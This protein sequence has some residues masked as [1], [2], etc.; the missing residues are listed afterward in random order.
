MFNEEELIKLHRDRAQAIVNFI[1]FAFV[2]IISRLVYLQIYRGEELHEFSIENRLR[3]EI[4]RAPRGMI[5]SRDNQLLVD[6]IPRFDA[7]L[8]RQFLTKKNDTLAKLSDIL[9]LPVNTIEKT[10][11]KH[12]DQAEYRPIIIEKNISL[13][14]V[15]KI[16]VNNSDLPGIS[17][18]TFISREYRDKDT[19]A[20]AL[21]YISEITQTQ[22]PRYNKRDNQEYRLGDF[23]GQFGLEQQADNILR[24][25]DGYEFVEVDA[26]GRKKRYISEDNI[27]KG[28]ENQASV[29]GKNIRLT[30]DRDLQ[31][32]A[33]EALDGKVGG[34]VAIEVDTGEVLSMI[35][36][37]SFDPS[38][39][40]KG[41]S[42][43]YWSSLV[44]NE[45]NPLRDRT[46]QEHYSPGSTYKPFTAIAA[47][48][49]NIIDPNTEI[50]CHGTL[51]FGRRVYH[52]WKKIGSYKVNVADALRESCN[53]FFYTIGTKIDIDVLANYSKMF[54][55]GTK[56]GIDLPREVSGLIATKDWKLKTTGEPWQQGET[57]SCSIG[58]SYTLSSIT[59][60]A[61]AYGAIA[62]EG[63]LYRPK[64]IKEI[65]DNQGQVV[66]TAKPDLVREIKLKPSTWK[67]V[68]EGLY[69]VANDPRGTAW[70]RKGV[71]NQMAGKTGT[72]QVVKASADKVY[73]KC[74]LMPVQN[75]H[76][77]LF[78]AFAPFDKPKIVAAA[79][80][81]HGCSGSGSAA[82]V[83]E[84]VISAYMKKYLPEDQLRYEKLEKSKIAAI[85]KK[86]QVIKKT[87]D[88][89]EGAPL[90][91]DELK[92]GDST[93][94]DD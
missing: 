94:E 63:K 93:P 25:V 55:L 37:P 36:T 77:G 17:V 3:R 62:N 9:Q 22:I 45:D 6:N 4:V 11:K 56:T 52:S 21:G 50:R 59:Q 75:R 91:I 54:G 71:G 76:H 14:E 16:E 58:Q 13:E 72:S 29:P 24:G 89:D 66:H 8:T 2:L 47:L 23:I 1:L 18:D 26:M 49:E 92:E 65:Y 53:I 86:S 78:V 68:K 5:Y 82:P 84:K 48:E 61:L 46:I 67:A 20:H 87:D 38:Q 80:V 33:K 34:L 64:I 90:K 70:W 27:F 35:S 42:S 7:T 60:L 51:T 40:S 85:Y 41:I 15:A 28:I 30:I 69:K 31:L 32:I 12:S 88:E 44:N 10:I 83:V 19:G 81:E 73:D 39:F 57:L 43:D 79:I 74:E